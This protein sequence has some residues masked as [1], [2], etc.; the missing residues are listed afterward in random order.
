MAEALLNDFFAVAPRD[1][2][3]SPIASCSRSMR[4]CSSF[5]SSFFSLF[6]AARSNNA[7]LL[8]WMSSIFSSSVLC[9]PAACERAAHGWFRPC[10]G[11]G[12]CAALPFGAGWAFGAACEWAALGAAL[13]LG[14]GSAAGGGGTA[15]GLGAALGFGPPRFSGKL[16]RWRL[17]GY[18]GGCGAALRLAEP[19]PMF[20]CFGGVF[21]AG[22][23]GGVL[24]AAV[25][26]AGHW[27]PQLSSSRSSASSA[28][29]SSRLCFWRRS[30][31]ASQASAASVLRSAFSR[32]SPPNAIASTALFRA[33]AFP[34]QTLREVWSPVRFLFVECCLPGGWDARAAA[35]PL[36]ALRQPMP[37]QLLA[38]K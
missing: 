23:L 18:A 21:G 31:P 12:A 16:L 8:S 24:G 15:G 27:G 25:L 17:G 13:A 1:A 34:I 32:S 20:F 29:L 2:C 22:L 3:A 19:D 36:R 5:A 10:G 33:M 7:I 6:L 28:I 11:C 35:G 37:T 38:P 4:A 9:E 26:G 30:L 14:G